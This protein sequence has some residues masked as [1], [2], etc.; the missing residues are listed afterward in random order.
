MNNGNETV[1]KLSIIQLNKE[2]KEYDTDYERKLW[3][4]ISEGKKDDVEKILLE[5]RVNLDWINSFVRFFFLNRLEIRKDNQTIS[6]GVDISSSS[7]IS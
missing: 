3:Y 2:I 6:L 1:R 4:S 7:I 5:A